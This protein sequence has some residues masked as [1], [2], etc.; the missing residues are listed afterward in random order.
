VGSIHT[1]WPLTGIGLSHDPGGRSGMAPLAISQ[2]RQD[3]FLAEWREGG[4]KVFGEPEEVS[5]MEGK[6]CVY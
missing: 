4:L 1:F 5:Y 3:V 2:K 6:V